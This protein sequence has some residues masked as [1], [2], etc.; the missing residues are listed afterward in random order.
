MIL[1]YMYINFSNKID[2]KI[3]ILNNQLLNNFQYFMHIFQLINNKQL[4]TLKLLRRCPMLLLSLL[5]LS[6]HKAL[7]RARDANSKIARHFKRHSRRRY[8][9]VHDA[10]LFAR[11]YPV[12]DYLKQIFHF[13]HN[14]DFRQSHFP[15]KIRLL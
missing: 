10:T 5:L 15:I 9:I 11:T 7:T 2:F 14:R 1:V 6:V 4:L 8:R 13:Y 12:S 3:I